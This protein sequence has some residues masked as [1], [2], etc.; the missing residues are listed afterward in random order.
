MSMGIDM[1]LW[2]LGW[3]GTTGG[4]GRFHPKGVVICLLPLAGRETWLHGATRIIL[5]RPDKSRIVR[6][7]ERID[8]ESSQMGL[9]ELKAFV[10]TK[11]LSQGSLT[12]ET[13][14]AARY[15]S[16]C[17]VATAAPVAP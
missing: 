9:A 8:S 7:S 17:R 6:P 10:R 11:P 12:G 15:W 2:A 3:A 16:I 14:W 5:R 13:G 4:I 1:R